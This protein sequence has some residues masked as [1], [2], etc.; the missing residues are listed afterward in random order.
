[1]EAPGFGPLPPVT[2]EFLRVVNGVEAARLCCRDCNSVHVVPWEDLGLPEDTPF[3]PSEPLWT[4]GLCGGADV[5]AE[6]EW[7]LGSTRANVSSVAHVASPTPSIPAN[8][9]TE[10]SASSLRNRL[11][12]IMSGFDRHPAKTTPPTSLVPTPIDSP[13]PGS[14]WKRGSM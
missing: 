4:C 10:I 7:P 1:M 5:S 3:P 6:P 9:G 12:A 11:D 13:A 14:K 8:V 2:I